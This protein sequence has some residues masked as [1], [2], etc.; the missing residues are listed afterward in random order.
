MQMSIPRETGKLPKDIDKAQRSITARVRCVPRTRNMCASGTQACSAELDV[1][2]VP[3]LTCIKHLLHM[4]LMARTIMSDHNCIQKP[5]Q[6]LAT[7][8]ALVIVE[9]ASERVKRP[10]NIHPHLCT[11]QRQRPKTHSCTASLQLHI[12]A[13]RVLLLR[14]RTEC[15]MRPMAQIPRVCLHSCLTTACAHCI[16]TLELLTVLLSLCVPLDHCS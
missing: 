6:L 5:L 7:H 14:G 1:V 9:E 11:K 10:L 2:L 12:P 15:Q 3:C 4:L 8:G 16:P 13:A